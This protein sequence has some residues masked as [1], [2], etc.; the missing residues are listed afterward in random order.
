M[1]TT[2]VLYEKGIRSALST[3]QIDAQFIPAVE[4]T[5]ID[6][7]ADIISIM[8]SNGGGQAAPTFTIKDRQDTPMVF[9]FAL[10]TPVAAKSA[11][12]FNGGERGERATGGLTWVCDTASSLVCRIKYKRP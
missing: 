4:E 3:R 9:G 12:S 11:I 8:V 2:I 7:D 6:G 5:V 10:D 1:A